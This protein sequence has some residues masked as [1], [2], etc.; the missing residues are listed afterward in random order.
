MN[1]HNASLESHRRMSWRE[2]EAAAL[3]REI[4]PWLADFAS[5]DTL[6]G[7]IV[8]EEPGGWW[9]QY[10]C[11]EHHVELLFDPAETSADVYR[12]PYGCELSGEPYRGAWLV[13]R[14]QQ[15]A[16]LALTAA[17]LH[18]ESGDA[19]E[20]ELARRLIVAYARQFPRYPVHPDAQ[21]WMLKGRAFHQ[22]L[23]EAIWATAL[24]RA[25]LLLRDA[26]EAFEEEEQAAV[27]RFFGLLRGSMEEYR[28][29]LIDVKN[30]PENNYMAWLNAA[31]A[32]LHA[33]SGD[34]A[35]LRALIEGP[36]GWRHHLSVGVKPDQLEFEGSVYY[37][38]FVLRAYLIFAEMAER[39]GIDL[40]A[41]EGG[42]GQSVRGML[43]AAAAFADGNGELEAP[44]DG[45]YVRL[46]YVREIAEVYEI[47]YA[48]FGEPAYVPVLEAAYRHIRSAV[49]GEGGAGE[50]AEAGAS[51]EPELHRLR[52]GLEAMLY[53]R[54][55]AA[56]G[57]AGRPAA[58]S[59]LLPHSG[60]AALRRPDSEL[61]AWIDFGGHGGSHG[62]DDKLHVS[63]RHRLGPV[64]P[65][66]GMVPYGSPMR[67]E[68]YKTTACH[69][70]V[71]VDCRSQA[72]HA[73]ELLHYE[74]SPSETVVRA[75]SAG[76]YP[77]CVIERELR[78][79]AGGLTDITEVRLEADGLIE[80]RLHPAAEWSL[81]D[82]SG[83]EAA[84]ARADAGD[85]GASAWQGPLEA[86][87]GLGA[88]SGAD[89]AAE[90]RLSLA[91]R[92]AGAGN[93]GALARVPLT[94][95]AIPGAKLYRYE[96]PGT[97]EDPARRRYGL[98][99][100]VKGTSADIVASYAGAKYRPAGRNRV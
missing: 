100:R 36:G 84:W 86:P 29:I 67:A 9:H 45:P 4:A 50:A 89:A 54:R 63:V 30:N 58:K 74:D 82:E 90:W 70:T 35:G 91:V 66:P 71:T 85:A 6:V 41:I 59:R 39:F 95:S 24:I 28:G 53:G 60:F 34:E 23:T 96:E 25:Y 32:G 43:D 99:I 37:H 68:W 19:K 61:S 92:S 52:C 62:H 93:G 2:R 3:R 75:R 55:D 8:P 77:G 80:W 94:L 64:A 1:R 79:S 69:N 57:A 40:C 88:A 22:A 27:D 73:G 20:A 46:P 78:L 33:A 16:R 11:P 48:R 56:S 97:A 21:P 81:L 42:Q 10:V 72:E 38:V 17:A 49:A 5:N 98:L 83:A 44:H 26:G 12:C 76:A 51:G 87:I 65:D 15:T 31:L 13:F 47:G 14:H 7:Y 18:A